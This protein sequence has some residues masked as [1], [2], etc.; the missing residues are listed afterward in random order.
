MRN[1][2]LKKAG[3]RMVQRGPFSST[4]DSQRFGGKITVAPGAPECHECG[5]RT[6]AQVQEPLTAVTILPKDMRGTNLRSSPRLTDWA[7]EAGCFRP[8]RFQGRRE[9][10]NPNSD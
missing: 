1:S 6:G 10:T 4:V 3:A 9:R 2:Y 7:Y 5:Y 8:R